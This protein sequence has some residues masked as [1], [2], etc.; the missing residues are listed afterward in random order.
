MPIETFQNYS[1]FTNDVTANTL[2][3][4]S[5]ILSGNTDV[6]Q[7]ISNVISNNSLNTTV[8]ANSSTTWNYQGT[9]IKQLTSDWYN[10]HTT[11]NS[12]SAS[13]INTTTTLNS[14]SATYVYL[15]S[16]GSPIGAGAT[17]N[18]GLGTFSLAANGVY[19]VIYDLWYA[20]TTAGTVVYLLS[21]V[22]NYANVNGR[23]S[24]T[25]AT[26]A[27]AFSAPTLVHINNKAL[28]VTPF[29]ATASLTTGATHNVSIM[30]NIINSGSPN[31][32]Q[33]AVS[34]PNTATVTPLAGSQGKITRL[35]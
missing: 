1:N 3:V 32:I 9:D 7:I 35:A 21:G 34:C 19:E 17:T 15:A 5:R 23:A 4:T 30:Y 22:N 26:G 25:I 6:T 11:L 20:K 13:W 27:S 29:P 2:Y 12:N 31:T 18:V 24:Q 14:N 8:N 28:A 10:D 16:I 33:I